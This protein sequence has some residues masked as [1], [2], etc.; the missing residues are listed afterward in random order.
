[1]SNIEPNILSELDLA[2]YKMTLYLVK[3]DLFS[4]PT[5]LTNDVDLLGSSAILVAEHGVEGAFV[6]DNMVM[7]SVVSPTD[8]YGYTTTSLI[9]FDLIET[10]GFSFLD[11]MAALSKFFSFSHITEA[12]FILKVEFVGRDPVSGR[13][14]S[15]PDVY[16]F[17]FMMYDIQAT[18]DAGGTR[19]TIFAFNQQRAGAINAVTE[20]SVSFTVKGDKVKDYLDGAVAA[21]N[22]M[23]G[24]TR[25]RERGRITYSWSMD[26]N[27]A[28]ADA[29]AI[30]KQLE[31][32]SMT[33]GAQQ[34][35]SDQVNAAAGDTPEDRA[36]RVF[37][38]EKSSSMHRT[39][40]TDI[41]SACQ[42]F[43]E[44]IDL[45]VSNNQFHP[46]LIIEPIYTPLEE[47]DPETNLQLATVEFKLS[48]Q[49]VN[50]TPVVDAKRLEELQ[51]TASKQVQFY[52]LIENQAICKKYDYLYTGLN[53][54]VLDFQLSYQAMFRIGLDPSYATAYPNTSGVFG[55]TTTPRQTNDYFLA[56]GMSAMSAANTVG[57][58][59]SPYKYFSDVRPEGFVYSAF[60]H[61][62]RSADQQRAGEKQLSTQAMRG[63][64]YA[65][66]YERSADFI[67]CELSIKGDPFWLG[68][69]GVK[70]NGE[71]PMRKF[72]GNQIAIAIIVERPD[73]SLA[74]TEN[75]RTG[76]I[77]YSSSGVYTVTTVESKFQQGRFTQTL[78]L[79]KNVNINPYTIADK[80][81][82]L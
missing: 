70:T 20:Q 8:R 36:N 44:M 58:K 23:E 49:M 27:V 56:N 31:S 51:T 62:G 11:R 65:S 80:I 66:Y 48:I 77:E 9:Q 28:D 39:I 24:K 42:E 16:F 72:S 12:R 34:E 61:V 78:E 4:D 50:D 37:S 6:I 63:T 81:V 41:M 76:G 67:N 57:N 53:S 38:F 10:L 5:P 54:E 74:D 75:R 82:N 79:R 21:L 25:R 68:T 7:K 55:V 26:T 35:K 33:T 17:A 47:K 1:M 69:P 13:G 2:T 14:V 22:S 32:M 3:P 18:M 15:V 45:K 40:Y 43:A 30:G 60:E 59:R 73:P 46:Y 64:K 52:E 19:Y 71:N 29:K